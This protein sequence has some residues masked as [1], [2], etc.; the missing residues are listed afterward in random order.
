MIFHTSWKALFNS[1]ATVNESGN[2]NRN[3][4]GF[5]GAMDFEANPN[6]KMM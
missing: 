1:L 5:T 3:I 4:V 6:V 2:Q